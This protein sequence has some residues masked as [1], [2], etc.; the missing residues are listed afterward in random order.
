MRGL[1][2]PGGAAG[3]TPKADA[4]HV[5]LLKDVVRKAAG[6]D[7][8]APVLVQQLACV[9]PGCPP[10]ETVIAALGPPRRTWKVPKPTADISPSQLRAVI[11]ENPEGI[12]HADHD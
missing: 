2:N 8:D 3:A 4:A 5:N 10:V 11:V 1:V 6:L 12:T 9:E 7:A